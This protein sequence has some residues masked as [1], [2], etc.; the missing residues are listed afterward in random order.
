MGADEESET[1]SKTFEAF[2]FVFGPSVLEKLDAGW[3][4]SETADG[5]LLLVGPPPREAA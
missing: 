4:I 2:D 1:K 5:Q 3:V